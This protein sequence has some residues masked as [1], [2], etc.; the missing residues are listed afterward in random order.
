MKLKEL[1][2][3]L[4]PD[5]PE[6][7]QLEE[8]EIPNQSAEPKST[9][10][11]KVV[12]ELKKLIELQT[13]ENKKLLD[14][15][16]KVKEAEKQREQL[17]A[18]KA[19][20]ETQ[21]KI[22]DAI[23]K[24]IEDKRIPAKDEKTIASFKKLLEADFESGEIALNALPKITTTQDKPVSNEGNQGPKQADGILGKILERNQI[25]N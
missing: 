8:P 2:K 5:K 19:K 13:A 24:A 25:V 23:K 15:L 17:L 20:Q 14:E 6:I 12:S 11:D 4:F 7:D 22:E 18:E 9:D 21:K 16:A 3:K 1:L 10:T